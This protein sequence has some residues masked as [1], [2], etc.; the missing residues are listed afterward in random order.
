MTLGHRTLTIQVENIDIVRQDVTSSQS[1][2]GTGAV[3]VSG[4]GK[5]QFQ[6]EKGTDDTNDDSED[7]HRD[8]IHLVTLYPIQKVLLAMANGPRRP[9]QPMRP[10]Q[11]LK[12]VFQN[13]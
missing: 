11:I 13:P 2:D 9:Q 1:S 7:R 10:V 4:G 8:V 12:K 6:G 3:V 5:C